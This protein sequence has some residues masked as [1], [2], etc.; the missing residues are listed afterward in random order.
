[1]VRERLRPPEIEQLVLLGKVRLRRLGHRWILPLIVRSWDDAGTFYPL[2]FVRNIKIKPKA[3]RP[4]PIGKIP[5]AHPNPN[6]SVLSVAGIKLIT[7]Y[8]TNIRSGP[9]NTNHLPT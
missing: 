8:D 7:K 9:R 6:P 4:R 5:N 2:P 1:M 3:E